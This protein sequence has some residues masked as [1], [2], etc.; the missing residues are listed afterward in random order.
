VTGPGREV[1][2]TFA[3]P[4]GV[5]PDEIAIPLDTDINGVPVAAQEVIA[6]SG[7]VV[8]PAEIPNN[9]NAIN[10]NGQAN[11]PDDLPI[12][13]GLREDGSSSGSGTPGWVYGVVVV[14]IIAIIAVVVLSVLLYKKLSRPIETV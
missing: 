14:G 4:P 2:S 6:P 13:I 8:L 10:N 7:G 3:V 5:I 1:P 9:G 11:I 12:F